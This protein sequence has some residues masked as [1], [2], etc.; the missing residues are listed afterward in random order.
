MPIIPLSPTLSSQGSDVGT[1]Y[2]PLPHEPSRYPSPNPPFHTLHPE[3]GTSSAQEVL[4]YSPYAGP[5]GPFQTYDRVPIIA[6]HCGTGSRMSEATG[7]I[8]F[9]PSPD[10]H[11]NS[12]NLLANLQDRS[13]FS[14]PLFFPAVPNL[15]PMGVVGPSSYATHTSVDSKCLDQVPTI[16]ANARNDS[17]LASHHGP[18]HINTTHNEIG[19]SQQSSALSGN[20]KGVSKEHI[21]GIK[22]RIHKVFINSDTKEDAVRQVNELDQKH[23]TRIY[24][25]VFEEALGCLPKLSVAWKSMAEPRFRCILCES[26]FTRKQNLHSK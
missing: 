13:A 14:I 16:S 21:L 9:A 2:S 8:D 24:R 12:S 26:L 19:V 22:R 3:Q 20:I 5:P 18:Q 11:T 1:F 10:A 7:N 17:Y 25:C 15:S 23:E 6:E 4:Q